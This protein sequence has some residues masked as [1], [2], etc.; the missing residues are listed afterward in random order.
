SMPAAAISAMVWS[1]RRTGAESRPKRC[2]ATTGASPASRSSSYENM[3]TWQSINIPLL[4]CRDD[5]VGEQPHGSLHS[6]VGNGAEVENAG[7]G[8]ELEVLGGALNGRDALVGVAV[9]IA[10]SFAQLL[11]RSRRGSARAPDSGD[12]VGALAGLEV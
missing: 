2:M 8:I 9:N 6:I 3:S 4:E 5:L 1:G 12:L 11:G 7:Q 10:T